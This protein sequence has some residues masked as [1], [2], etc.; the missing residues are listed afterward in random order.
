[1]NFSEA[2]DLGGWETHTKV[3]TYASESLKLLQDCIDGF[4]GQGIASIHNAISLRSILGE[5]IS[6]HEVGHSNFFLFKFFGDF[7]LP[8]N[9]KACL[10]FSDLLAAQSRLVQLIYL[11]FY[12]PLK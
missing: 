9:R 4:N 3:S 5:C 1:M 11:D 2:V 10:D 7:F 8:G 12:K 6:T